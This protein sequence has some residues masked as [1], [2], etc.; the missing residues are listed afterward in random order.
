MY[1]IKK[2]ILLIL[3]VMAVNPEG[4]AQRFLSRTATE[5]KITAD[6]QYAKANNFVGNEIPLYFDL[7]EPMHD[8]IDYRPLVITV[9]GGSFV[10]GN[11][12]WPDMRAFGDSL[13]HY[14]YVVAS[15]DY[16][17]GY[18][19]F[20]K[21]EIYRAAYRATQ[22]INAAIRYFK[23][24]YNTYG[25]DTT[26]I[27]LLGSSAGGIASLTSA[28]LDEEQ[29]PDITYA[30][31]NNLDDLGCI[32]CSGDNN[33]HT[34]SVA[35]VI[36]QWGGMNNPAYIDSR[37]S[38]PVCFIHG[39]ND[40]IVPYDVGPAYKTQLMPVLFGSEYLSNRMNSLS[41]WN[42]LHLF[43]DEKHCFYLKANLI[44]DPPK[45]D[46]CLNI[47][48]NFMSKLNPRVNNG[49]GSMLLTGKTLTHDPVNLYRTDHLLYTDNKR[50]LENK[51]YIISLP[52]GRIIKSGNTFFQRGIDMKPLKNGMYIFETYGKRKNTIQTVTLN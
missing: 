26:S 5:I 9:F 18:N 43:P 46:T 8:S 24:N 7:Y 52:D 34:N 49:D 22:D 36:A 38:T 23:A 19:P 16:R 11:K 15:I 44:I 28:F 40:N 39:V 3:L 45:F 10:V 31:E 4:F 12:D 13:A 14:G 27:F 21:R 17:L 33:N 37:D 41:I 6:I 47:I 1:K 35:G 50:C 30:L 42:E 2:N 20:D 29:R 48:V 25:I 32:N 51:F